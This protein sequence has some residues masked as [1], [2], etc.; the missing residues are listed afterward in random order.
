MRGR[1][2]VRFKFLLFSCDFDRHHIACKASGVCL[3]CNERT[4]QTQSLAC[5]R[6]PTLLVEGHHTALVDSYRSLSFW[7]A[8][9]HPL[10]L[11]LQASF[12]YHPVI[13]AK[14]CHASSGRHPPLQNPN[15][16]IICNNCEAKHGEC[17][18]ERRTHRHHVCFNV[19]CYGINAWPF[20]KGNLHAPLDIK[21]DY[22]QFSDLLQNKCFLFCWATFSEKISV[23]PFQESIVCETIHYMT[24][25]F[26]VAFICL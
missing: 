26:W 24:L 9:P 16:I 6:L 10:V 25:M 12:L 11:F 4:P 22:F 5:N 13:C 7:P 23:H 18:D 1:Q 8:N 21:G 20:I 19:L 2:S 15:V 14:T 17:L 3:G